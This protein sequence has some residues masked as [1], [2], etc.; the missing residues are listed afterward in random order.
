MGTICA[1]LIA[2]LYL[3]CYER[4]LMALHSYLKEAEIIQSKYKDN[5]QELIQLYPTSLP[6]NETGKKDTH[7]TDKRS[8][9]KHA[10]SKLNE[11][12]FNSTSRYLVVL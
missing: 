3:L 4:D 7:K 1:P 2:D 10:H 11:Q 8:Q 9:N 6:K 5:D 12:A